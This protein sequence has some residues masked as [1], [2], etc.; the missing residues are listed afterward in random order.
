MKQQQLAL[1]FLSLALFGSVILAHP[2]PD[3]ELASAEEVTEMQQKFE[4]NCGKRVVTCLKQTDVSQG[5]YY[6]QTGYVRRNIT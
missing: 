1:L 6:Y 3:D 4:S 5:P 2:D